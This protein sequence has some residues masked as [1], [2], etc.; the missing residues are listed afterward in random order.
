MLEMVFLT[1]IKVS[2]SA[3]I[4]A[5]IVIVLRQLIGEIC[6]ELLVMLRGL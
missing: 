3:S 6:Q 5:I 4:A 2:V 1:V